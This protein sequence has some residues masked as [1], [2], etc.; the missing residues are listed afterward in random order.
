MT[1]LI[2]PGSAYRLGASV[3]GDGTNFALF[4]EHAERV[5]LCLFD[6]EGFETRLRMPETT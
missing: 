6:D 5:E 4:A 2:W 3:E 1:A